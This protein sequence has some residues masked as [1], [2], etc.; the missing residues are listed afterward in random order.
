MGYK[1]ATEFRSASMNGMSD[2]RCGE[3]T[4]PERR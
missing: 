3:L 1:T 4:G 2:A